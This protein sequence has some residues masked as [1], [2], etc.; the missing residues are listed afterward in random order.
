MN[1]LLLAVS[2][3]FGAPT[4]QDSLPGYLQKSAH[5][6]ERNRKLEAKA[7]DAG[8]VEYKTEG[9][10]SIHL[11]R[12]GRLLVVDGSLTG[13]P[14]KADLEQKVDAIHL[15]HGGTKRP[16]KGGWTRKIGT[17]DEDG[18]VYS[19]EFDENLT[20][21]EE[22]TREIGN[23]RKGRIVEPD[24]LVRRHGDNEG[25]EL[26]RRYFGPKASQG[27]AAKVVIAF[28]DTGLD[29]LIPLFDGCIVPGKFLLSSPVGKDV[30]STT[31]DYNGHGTQ[32]AGLSL[33]V[34]GVLDGEKRR[35]V[36]VMPLKTMN[37]EGYGALSDMIEGIGWAAD[38]GAKVINISAGVDQ[39]S[40]LL[41]RAV[42]MATRRGV[43]IL[44]SAGNESRVGSVYPAGCPGAVSVGSVG[45]N[46]WVAN[47]SNRG[48]G[49][50]IYAQGESLASPLADLN[51]DGAS[52]WGEAS[53]TSAS[54]AL[55]TGAI[56]LYGTRGIPAVQARDQVLREA[57]LRHGYDYSTETVKVLNVGAL[58]CGD[59][60]RKLK[61]LSVSAS[62]VRT[63]VV[64]SEEISI[65][66]LI[67]N[68]GCGATPDTTLV[69]RFQSDLTTVDVPVKV[70][71]LRPLETASA[72]V[73]ILAS[74][75]CQGT[76]S[77]YA[78][79][80][81]TNADKSAQI[82]GKIQVSPIS[83]P[84][85]TLHNGWVETNPTTGRRFLRMDLVNQGSREVKNLGL[86]LAAR[87]GIEEGFLRTPEVQVDTV[88]IASLKPGAIEPIKIQ[89]ADTLQSQDRF[90]VDALALEGKQAVGE[91]RFDFQRL[92]SGEVK[93]LYNQMTHERQTQEAIKLL[94]MHGMKLADLSN[95]S[96]LGA[97]REWDYGK[98]AVVMM[99]TEEGYVSGT[100]Y[101]L[102][103]AGYAADGM[104]WT[105]LS[106]MA[107][108]NDI[109]VVDI[110]FGYSGANTFDSHFWLVDN[111]DDDGLNSIGI[112][113][114]SALTKIRAL[115]F[116]RARVSDSRWKYGAIDLYL[117]GKKN[118]AYWL[119]GQAAHLVGDMSVPEHVDNDN[120]HGVWGSAY[121]NWMKSNSY[122][123]TAT[124]AWNNGNGGMIN[125][126][127]IDGKFWALPTPA[128][129][130]NNDPIR[131]LM[132]TTA[133]VANIFPWYSL[134][135]AGG[136]YNGFDGNKYLGGSSPHYDLY[137]LPRFLGL[138]NHPRAMR[139][140]GKDE[141]KDHCVG[142]LCRTECQEV[143]WV[144]F[145][146]TYSDCWDG[147]NG[148]TDHDNTDNDGSDAD[149]DLSVI[150]A[151]SY[152]NGIRS[153]AGLLYFF[154]VETGQFP[155]R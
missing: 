13:A 81:G 40:A 58:H 87:L 97:T 14:L 9:D 28:L 143:D 1:F 155:R 83:S 140:L 154:G 148:H 110:T 82:L 112:N 78:S 22:M 63:S 92:N 60:L 5:Q 16:D 55:V 130:A 31:M 6:A 141:V 65:P 89:L 46:G 62:L 57:L 139:D 128:A 119:L 44:A 10:P 133:Q 42:R 125:P 126:Y 27:D 144:S 20:T 12:K 21:A 93:I 51:R 29:G 86:R 43:V 88:R 84:V 67:A 101:Y 8:F 95:A 108:L 90:A 134:G 2:F 142:L 36:K 114:H 102:G 115:L 7:K 32:M 98:T 149:G 35:N 71:A 129:L 117:H 68:G 145:K 53:G 124:D 111:S 48:S 64:P 59:S 19:V 66:L 105:D 41:D 54:A 150:A 138:P 152:V 120:W 17:L 49:V 4:P 37:S 153:V 147:G 38:H 127:R 73:K 74:K 80:Q 104:R 15:R 56:A 11:R 50:A 100:T 146:E 121:E 123:W 132:Y 116:G 118:A 3:A 30:D 109:D 25:R 34:A 72:N 113:H 85:V 79:I 47:F 135:W 136:F 24:Q 39:K 75:V 23:G 77:V 99:G 70:K 151:N 26:A 33:G 103:G 107:G 18:D 61:D 131:F 69:V 106:L 45:A 94:A 91:R 96:Y 122:R 52:V 137:M 76:C